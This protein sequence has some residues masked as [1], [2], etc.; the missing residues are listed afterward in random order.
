[1]LQSVKIK[2]GEKITLSSG[3]YSIDCEIGAGGFGTVYKGKKGLQVF[4]IKLNR[5]WELLPEDREDLRKRIKLEFEI[6]NTIF[7][8]HL[9][10]TFSYDEINEN[11]ILVMDYCPDG[12]LRSRIGKPFNPD[13]INRISYQIL[14]G[15]SIL[16]SYQI[17]HRDIKP[18]NVLF[19]KDNALLTDFGISANLKNRV[20]QRNIRGQA[21]KIFATLSYSPPEQSSKNL[22]FKTTGPTNDIFSFGVI[23][24]EIITEG[25]LPFGDVRNFEEDSKKVEERKIH[26]E[27]DIKTLKKYTDNKSLIGIIDRCLQPDPKMRFQSASEIIHELKDYKSAKVDSNAIWK[28]T[29]VNGCDEGKEFNLTNLS[30]FKDKRILTIG[31][32]DEADPLANDISLHEESGCYISLH[33]GT[34]EF[35]LKDNFSVWN[36]R[37]G[38]WYSKYGVVGWYCSRN[39]IKVNNQPVSK[40]GI[41][42]RHKD[43]IK[44]GETLLEINNG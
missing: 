23:L 17:I 28:L 7:S 10:R 2:P 31:R 14:T 6:S 18:E 30:R 16:H 37:D 27:W 12:S 21:L 20:T 35:A 40:S 38:Q 36:L 4:A 11:P 34:F 26:G 44:I 19:K 24:Y 22:A 33:H 39:G 1:M 41:E 9:V 5:M 25:L 13:E 29:V 3:I 43:Q 15:L 32:F 42:L 8:E